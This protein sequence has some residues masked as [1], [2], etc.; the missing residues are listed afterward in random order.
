[1]ACPIHYNID[2]PLDREELVDHTV[3]EKT[4][5]Y[6]K[7]PAAFMI[8]SCHDAKALTK[9]PNGEHSR[10][11]HAYKPLSI[12]KSPWVNPRGWRATKKL[13]P[14]WKLSEDVV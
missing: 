7:V 2:D 8:I 9:L 3:I 13:E 1:M 6:D 12:T 5:L 4:K 11:S 10:A 14:S